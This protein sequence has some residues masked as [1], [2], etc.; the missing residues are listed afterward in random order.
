MTPI[1]VLLGA[2]AL[3]P[4]CCN[5]RIEGV[6]AQIAVACS[7]DATLMGFPIWTRLIIEEQKVDTI[8]F[9]TISDQL[10]SKKCTLHSGNLV[11]QGAK[12][13]PFSHISC[14]IKHKLKK[15]GAFTLVPGPLVAPRFISLNP[16]LNLAYL[17]CHCFLCFT[18][19]YARLQPRTPKTL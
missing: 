17:S 2:F 15:Q 12:E 6:G 11:K 8:F 18:P 1:V 4:Y 3:Q 5:L 9:G 14:W 19:S 13:A 10:A 16:S 7:Q